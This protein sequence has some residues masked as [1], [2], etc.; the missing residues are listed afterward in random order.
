MYK[1]KEI[2]QKLLDLNALKKHYMA[3]KFGYTHLFSSYPS[4]FLWA[5]KWAA[6]VHISPLCASLNENY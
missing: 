1:E 5:D 3:F 2:N 6:I 4:S